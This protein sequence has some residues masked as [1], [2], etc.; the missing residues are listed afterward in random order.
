[1]CRKLGRSKANGVKAMLKR[2]SA[3]MRFEAHL[4]NWNG[5]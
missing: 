2:N 3:D 4:L 1:M 5:G